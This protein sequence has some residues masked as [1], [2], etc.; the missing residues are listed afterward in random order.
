[1]VQDLLFNLHPPIL[2]LSLAS[3]KN[4]NNANTSSLSRNTNNPFSPSTLCMWFH[5]NIGNSINSTL[6]AHSP[7]HQLQIQRPFPVLNLM[8]LSPILNI[9]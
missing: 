9:S 6:Q 5:Q 2:N 1:V 3:M 7:R 8:M 4:I